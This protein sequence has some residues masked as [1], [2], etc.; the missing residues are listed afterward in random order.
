[1]A[2]MLVMAEYDEHHDEYGEY[3]AEY[4]DEMVVVDHEGC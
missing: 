3:H 2:M 1:M 4:D